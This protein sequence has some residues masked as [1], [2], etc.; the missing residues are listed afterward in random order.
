MKRWDDRLFMVIV[1]VMG[2]EA[3]T[4]VV[5]ETMDEAAVVATVDIVVIVKVG[6][7]SQT[8]T[9]TV[10][11]MTAFFIFGIRL[12]VLMTTQRVRVVFHP[13][14]PL[15]GA[16]IVVV[17]VIAELQEPLRLWKVVRRYMMIKGALVS[18]PSVIL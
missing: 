5:I 15:R 9:V 10:G 17:G 11:P 16:A 6:G 12:I 14:P 3:T 7:G 18:A 2:L 1:D 4:T 13:S 8:T